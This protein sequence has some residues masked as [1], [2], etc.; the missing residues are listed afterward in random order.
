MEII[1]A[2]HPYIQTPEGLPD[3]TVIL[4]AAHSAFTKN[5]ALKQSWAEVTE[6]LISVSIIPTGFAPDEVQFKNHTCFSIARKYQCTFICHLC[7]LSTLYKNGNLAE[8][9][10]I[11]SLCLKTWEDLNFLKP[12]L[13]SRIFQG[14]LL[15][16]PKPVNCVPTLPLNRLTY[17]YLAEAVNKETCFKNIPALIAEILLEKNR[18]KLRPENKKTIQKYLVELQENSKNTTRSQAINALKRLVP[19]DILPQQ[20]E[21]KSDLPGAKPQKPDDASCLEGL[22]KDTPA[23]TPNKGKQQSRKTPQS[24]PEPL[25]PVLSGKP[26]PAETAKTSKV[27]KSPIE[28]KSIKTDEA[29]KIGTVSTERSY[30][31]NPEFHPDHPE[32]QLF[33]RI[34][35]DDTSRLK[36]EFEE[37]LLLNPELAV[38][39]V[40]DAHTKKEGL[41]LYGSG[42]FYFFALS[43]EEMKDILSLYV[44][45]SRRR[46]MICY[47]PYRLIHFL[48]KSRIPFHNLVSLRTV[49]TVIDRMQ[50]NNLKKGTPLEVICSSAALSAR[51]K[52]YPY[53]VTMP[54]YSQA[55]KLLSSK[56]QYLDNL[57]LITNAAK[58]DA[59]LG[60]SFDLG[61]TTYTQSALFTFDHKS[62]Y[63]FSYRK[64]ADKLK[65]GFL[66]VEYQFDVP[67]GSEDTFMTDVLLSIAGQNLFSK[68]RC[69]LLSYSRSSLILSAKKQ[70]AP[71]L[72]ELIFSLATG[73]G[74]K[75]H[76]PP[77]SVAET[78]IDDA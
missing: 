18:E 44:G 66:S 50:K 23:A 27:T 63:L 46:L 53:F 60:I 6:H 69:R 43:E 7:P 52:P 24:E 10:T 39:I 9:K 61:E 30:F 78:I 17:E 34:A 25:P 26:S 33:K 75:L 70:D 37:F 32:P 54:L 11:L 77:I 40:I 55:W 8:E 3:H 20:S 73:I 36:M 19:D 57:Q 13:N 12:F 45:K 5:P 74:E 4:A 65:E 62:R 67:N 2:C 22:L 41:L 38:E 42:V 28:K 51:H 49:T 76:L 71:Y 21:A 47:E 29:M 68:Y 56:K 1:P 16:N 35:E 15:I 58:L 31:L 59:L 72:C 14:Q 64:H 48:N